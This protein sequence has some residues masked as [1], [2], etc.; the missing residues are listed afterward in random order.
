MDEIIICG[1][2]LICVLIFILIFVWIWK[3]C[4]PRGEPNIIEKAN[5]ALSLYRESKG[6]DE[7]A[8]SLVLG[9]LIL[10]SGT[11][12]AI[13]AFFGVVLSVMSGSMCGYSAFDFV[14]DVYDRI[15]GKITPGKPTP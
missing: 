14:F 1:L 3:L 13:L 7:K 6:P 5:A 9:I 12:T 2:A 10:L 15:E 4:H 8:I 11:K